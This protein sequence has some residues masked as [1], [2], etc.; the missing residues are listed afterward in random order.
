MIKI[1]RTKGQTVMDTQQKQV[2]NC[3]RINSYLHTHKNR[4]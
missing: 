1:K 4:W 3:R 2:E